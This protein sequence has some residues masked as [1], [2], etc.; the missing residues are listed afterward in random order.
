MLPAR[1]AS[2]RLPAAP[3]RPYRPRRE[4]APERRGALMGWK[5]IQD[6]LAVETGAPGRR[7]VLLLLA[8]R[9]CDA[10]GLAWPGITWL[11]DNAE[12]SERS[13]Q[14][15]LA[16]L[17]GAGIVETRS[18]ATGGR[19]RS[20]EYVVMPSRTELS[21]APCAECGQRRRNPVKSAGY[22]APGAETPQ[23]LR[24]IGGANS[25]KPRQN[26]HQKGVTVAP[27]QQ[28]NQDQQAAESSLPLGPA[29]DPTPSGASRVPM[30]TDVR[31]SLQSLGVLSP[32]PEV[33]KAP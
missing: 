28:E 22:S 20:T 9:S 18:Y 15:A 2:W 27:H 1:C 10:C 30:P 8:W 11:C 17:A 29:F 13:V 31:E 25:G 24:G 12:M 14:R 4:H 32:D 5:A 33:G 26:R 16:E 3:R 6:S 23:I 21:T 7:L 19:G